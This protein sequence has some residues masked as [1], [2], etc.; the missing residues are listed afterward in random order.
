MSGAVWVLVTRWKSVETTWGLFSLEST[1]AL[2]RERREVYAIG[3]LT[4]IAE[5]VAVIFGRCGFFSR[6]TAD[7]RRWAIKG[8]ESQGTVGLA[9]MG[10]SIVGW[11]SH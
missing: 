7:I 9:E 10:R 5:A 2:R 4:M 6:S 8:G 3:V 11:L 1:A